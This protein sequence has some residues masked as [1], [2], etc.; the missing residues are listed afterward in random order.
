MN[1]FTFTLKDS[2]QKAFNTFFWFLYFLHLVIAAVI[3][4]N[5]NDPFQKKC[6]IVT[7]TF[8]LLAAT[9]FYLF[10]NKFKLF[11]YQLA[12]FVAMV[13]FWIIQSAWLPAV[14]CGVIIAFVLKVLTI[15]STA[16]FTA[17]D[18]I[19]IKSIFKKT[20]SWSE[21]DN[22]VL[23][24]GLLSVDLKNNHLVQMEVTKESDDINEADFN[25]FC[26]QQ[27]QNPIPNS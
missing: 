15:K 10:K 25:K 11:T 18:I 3:I 13:T 16:K 22:V 23:K 12:M 9:L 21:I 24:D 27:L 14:I 20:Y 5:T 6:A 2:T 4:T 19:M 7:F 26:T 8:L 17:T 1:Q